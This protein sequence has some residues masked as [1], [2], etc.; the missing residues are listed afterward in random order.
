MFRA[1]TD[2][3]FR[4]PFP[5]E[6]ILQTVRWYVSYPLSYRMIE[7]L[8]T[9]RGVP[10]DHSTINRWVVG[11]CTKLEARHRKSK[12]S[13]GNS[14]RMDETYIKVKGQDHYL[15]RAVDK[16]GNTIDFL[17]TKKRDTK[18]AKAFF[19]KAIRQNGPPGKVAIDKSGANNYALVSI[20]TKLKDN[21][22][23]IIIYQSNYLNNIVEQDH[24]FV[25][26]L[27]RPMMQFKNFKTAKATLAGIELSHMLRKGQYPDSESITP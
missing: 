27:T 18:A 5:T 19:R 2:K 10:V 24:R 1:S 11:I 9:E 14:W 12:P 20:N 22:P 13:V 7:E 3:V 26:R 6:I 16:E 15:Y 21:D 17:L 8:L 25:K 4:P 23:K